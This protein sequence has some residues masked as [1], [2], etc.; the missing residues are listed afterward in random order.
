MSIGSA[1]VA[2]VT[3]GE[4][5]ALSGAERLARS[6]R[7]VCDSVVRLPAGAHSAAFA[8]RLDAVT[9]EMHL[10][11]RDSSVPWFYDDPR[12]TRRSREKLARMAQ[13][14]DELSDFNPMMPPMKIS[15]TDTGIEGTVVVG[16]AFTG[17]PG[18][19]HGG[20]HSKIL[21]HM[22]GMLVATTGNPAVTARLEVDFVRGAPIGTE[23]ALSARIERIAGR[24]IDVEG[25]ISL[26]GE[27][28]SRGRALFVVVP[29]PEL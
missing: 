9:R 13:D 10:Y 21:D 4:Q 27:V 25:T 18:M 8:D 24:K 19:V 7:A 22:M 15:V 2:G 5:S 17:P 16:P 6:V 14:R 28:C 11:V 20:T 26:N 23:L 1:P 29:R 12:T 3:D